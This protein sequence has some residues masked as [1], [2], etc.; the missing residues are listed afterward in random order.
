[1]PK[2]T[3]TQF[4][5][6]YEYLYNEGIKRNIPVDDIKTYIRKNL[7]K[8]VEECTDENG[9]LDLCDSRIFFVKMLRISF[10]LFIFTPQ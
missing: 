1:M 3:V 4:I 9:I 10:L 8:F 2:K 5:D 7:D 6:D